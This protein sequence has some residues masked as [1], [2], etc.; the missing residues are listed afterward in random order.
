MAA[1]RS[2]TQSRHSEQYVSIHT[3]DG[4]MSTVDKLNQVLQKISTMNVCVGHPENRF[5][6]VCKS[7]KGEIRNNSGDVV[8]YRDDYC[9]VTLHGELHSFKEV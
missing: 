8:A 9:P 6:E 4:A 3:F 5:L 2:W 1:V 7:R